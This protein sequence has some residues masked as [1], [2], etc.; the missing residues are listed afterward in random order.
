MEFLVHME[1]RLPADTDA[2][3]RA[4][5]TESEHARARALAAAGLIRRL[6][7]VPGRRANWGLWDAP[8]G[9]S[10]HAAIA[11]LPL[12]PWLEVT[13]YPL[14]AHENDPRA[15][16]VPARPVSV[17]RASRNESA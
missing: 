17:S 13:V 2:T 6:W 7:R 14:A 9:S 1:V 3:E 10:L 4:R 16:S 5:L 15:G 8:D 12:Y 11:S